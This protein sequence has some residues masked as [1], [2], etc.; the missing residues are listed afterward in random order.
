MVEPSEKAVN[1]L[2]VGVAAF[3]KQKFCPRRLAIFGRE[4][5]DIHDR[6]SLFPYSRT[7]R[8]GS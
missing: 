5:G 1:A 7:A 2:V 3:V 8:S 4:V 6:H